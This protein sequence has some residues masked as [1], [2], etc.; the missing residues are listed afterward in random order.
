[1][2]IFKVIRSSESS[3]EEFENAIHSAR[4]CIESVLDNECLDVKAVADTIT[5]NS[6]DPKRSIDLTL[7]ECKE[8]IR[9][10]FLDASGNMYPEFKKIEP[11]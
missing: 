1:M 5:I 7:S 9:G 6:F 4:A 3:S 11:R 8:K 10:C 2:Y